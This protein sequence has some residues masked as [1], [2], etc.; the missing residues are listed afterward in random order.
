MSVTETFLLDCVHYSSVSGD[1]HLATEG[2]GDGGGGG[3]AS[4][5]KA[6]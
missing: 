3:G 1:L 4:V 5:N 6:V 2:T